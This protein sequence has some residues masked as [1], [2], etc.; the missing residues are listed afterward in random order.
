MEISS[1]NIFVKFA[2]E[3]SCFVVGDLTVLIN[4][5]HDESEVW[6]KGL[7]AMIGIRFRR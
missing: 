2:N 5:E 1:H 4:G 6:D 7:D 3:E